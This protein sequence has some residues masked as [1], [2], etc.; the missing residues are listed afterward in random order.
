M[1]IFTGTRGASSLY[2]LGRLSNSLSKINFSAFRTTSLISIKRVQSIVERDLTVPHQTKHGG[3][4]DYFMRWGFHIENFVTFKWKS[5]KQR[6][7]R[8]QRNREKFKKF[9]SSR[10][11]GNS[12]I[13]IVFMNRGKKLKKLNQPQIIE[14]TIYFFRNTT[15]RMIQ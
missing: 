10:I 9:S 5:Q 4:E 14:Y 1:N 11:W 6:K 7:Q 12:L 15:Q 8:K 13:P 2:S 3:R